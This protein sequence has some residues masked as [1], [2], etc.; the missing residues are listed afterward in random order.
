M[1]DTSL[2]DSVINRMNA[3]PEEQTALENGQ[4]I[5]VQRADLF[6]L[7]CRELAAVIQKNPKHPKAAEYRRAIAQCPPDEELHIEKIDLQALLENK[8]IDVTYEEGVSDVEGIK[9][10]TKYEIKKLGKEIDEKNQ[11]APTSM[12]G[13]SAPNQPAAARSIPRFPGRSFISSP[14]KTGGPTPPAK[15]PG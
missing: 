2:A 15:P 5:K 14:G 3:P 1:P 4:F 12:A 6:K 8:A 10:K 7:T 11:V 13:D 9:M